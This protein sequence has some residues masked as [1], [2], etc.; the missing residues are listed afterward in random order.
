MNV[1][2]CSRDWRFNPFSARR[3]F[4]PR[5]RRANNACL[6]LFYQITLCVCRNVTCVSAQILW[7]DRKVTKHIQDDCVTFVKR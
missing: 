1:A 7:A 5:R 3:H 6:C 2:C 4:R